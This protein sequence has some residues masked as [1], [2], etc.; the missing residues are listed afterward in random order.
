MSVGRLTLWSIIL[1]AIFAPLAE[2]DFRRRSR[3]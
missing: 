3:D 2:A 1:T